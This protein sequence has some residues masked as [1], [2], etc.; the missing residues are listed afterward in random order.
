VNWFEFKPYVPV[1]QRRAEARKKI[2][3]LG[4]TTKLSPVEISGKKIA[5]TWWGASWC[6]NLERYADFENRIGRGRSYVRN[7]QVIDLSISDGKVASMV[8]GSELYHVQ[9]GID[10]LSKKTWRTVAEQVGRRIGSLAELVEGKFPEELG[11]IFMRQGEGLFPSPREIHMQCDCPD[12]AVMCKHVAATL[13]GIG[14][15]LD[16]E[17]LLFFKLRGIPFEE[18]L[19]KSVDEKMKKLLKNAHKKTNR[20]LKGD[21]AG[22]FGL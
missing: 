12:Y 1:A 9:I 7:G 19:K 4:K 14:A 3:A 20:V 8:M 5:R 22:I 16:T 18:L 15:R 11:E 17:P 2:A 6:A 10:G 13:Y 21:V